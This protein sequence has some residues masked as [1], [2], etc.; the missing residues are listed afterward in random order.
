MNRITLL[1]LILIFLTTP[2]MA[3][4]NET[5]IKVEEVVV[6]A[7]RY[8]ENPASV[9][10]ST[11]VITEE[12]IN[13]STARNIP[14]LLR[15][16]AGVHVTDT[17]GNKRNMTVDLRGFGETAALNTLVLV[18]GR[19]VNQADLSGTDWTQIPL[20]RVK[21]I[22]IIRGGRGS[23]LYGDNASGGVI[24]IITKE[25]E[26]LKA[27]AGA[28][29]GSFET[30]KGNA[31]FSGGS[32]NLY[33]SVNGSYLTSD[34][35]RDNS[36]TESKDAGVNLN[37][38]IGD[39][40]RLNFSSGYHKDN[41]GLPGSLK[42]SDFDAGASRTDSVNP[43]DFADVED[44]YF[45]GGPEVYFM[46]NGLVKL[47]ISYRKRD[48]L[49]FSSFAAGEF[50]GDTAVRT[51]AFSPQLVLKN[52]LGDASNTFTIG[53]DYQKAEEDIVNDS[54]FF[55][56]RTMGEFEL[57]KENYGY[58]V[59]DEISLTDNLLFSGGYRYDRAEFTF[60][61]STPDNI[62]MDEDLYTAGI[63][64]TFYR[65]SYA[66]ASVSKSFRYPVLDE[67]FSFFTNTIDTGLIPQK[68]NEY[69]L[70]ARFYINDNCYIHINVFR[71]DTNDEI[72]YNP[73]TYANENLDGKSRRDGV[74]ISFS[75]QPLAWVT[76]NGS[77]TY[78]D[79]TIKEGRFK[80]SDIPGVPDR[81]ASLATVFSLSRGFSV[82]LNGI[83]VSAR[84]FISDFENTY[85]AQEDYTV[86]NSKFKYQWEALTA[87]LDINNITDEEYSEYGVIGGF[88]AEKAYY[89]S[90]GRNFLAGLTFDF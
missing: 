8:E 45:K 14:D 6:T 1:T 39:Y 38:Y 3:D 30:Y 89:P 21:K 36:S 81:K 52:E 34:G 56:S 48:S 26:T 61:P 79:A 16:E 25:G 18:D 77:Y 46:D 84:P 31:Y 12:G 66:Y 55:G 70:G 88:P 57:E 44:Y 67:L 35:Y 47:D 19:R 59:H 82:M 28:A 76:L 83:Y 60:S 4:E 23:V 5:T 27:G 11:T 73:S 51:L 13:N 10:A 71:I 50:T 85:T 22:E 40:V 53:I 62:T 20:D 58:Y 78:Q 75:A 49:T 87:F 90:P 69:E 17:G 86:I 42:E 65:K 68:S 54:L 32:G 24:N 43:D 74:E 41:T 33:Y 2:L 64:Y 7:T 9:P 29:A 63:N 37:Y 15:T 80:G 72:F